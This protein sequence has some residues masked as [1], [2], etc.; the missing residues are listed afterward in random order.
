MTT[1]RIGKRRGFA[2]IWGWALPACMSCVGIGS[3]HAQVNEEQRAAR[4]AQQ[5]QI[6]AA[7]MLEANQRRITVYDR[8]GNEL[9]TV[10]EPDIYGAPVLSPDRSR[11]AVIRRGPQLP[12][13]PL[14]SD[15]VVLDIETEEASRVTTSEPGE[16]PQNVV[17]SPDGGELAF[18]ALRGSRYNIYRRPAV[19]EG[20]AT[21]VY[22][23]EGEPIRLSDWSP[24]GR[25]LAFSS[26]ANASE[27]RLYTIDLESGGEPVV[28]AEADQAMIAPRFSPDSRYLAFLSL[29]E[30]SVDHYVMPVQA[31]GRETWRISANGTASF[32]FWDADDPLF[33]HIDNERRLMAISIDTSGDSFEF[34]EERHIATLPDTV[35]AN[36]VL[37]LFSMSHD[38]ERLLVSLPPRPELQQIA[39]WD[40]NGNEISRLGEPA[41]YDQPSFS[42]DGSRI[43]VQRVAEGGVGG[44][45]LLAFDVASGDAT[46]LT[47]TPPGFWLA[48]VWMPDG[49]HVAYSTAPLAPAFGDYS[50]IYR[51]RADGQGEAEEL[52]RSAT[53][54]LLMLG[55]MDVSPGN[56]YLMFDSAG[57][58]VTV[59]L[60][61]G[62]PHA[63]EAIDLLGAEFEAS[64]S[65]FSPDMRSV[66]YLYN[67]SGRSEVY[68]APFDTDAGMAIASERHQVSEAGAAGA[69]D[70]REDGRELYYLS[71]ILD[72]PELNDF[73]VMAV[74]VTPEPEF[75]T[76]EP[77]TLFDVTLPATITTTLV[78]PVGTATLP[79]WQNVSPDG[80]RFAFVLPASGAE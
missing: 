54:V 77:R 13:M 15:I 65:R 57:W 6:A 11:I 46:E 27:G 50:R 4:E 71:E 25:Y 28:V 38:G 16:G 36:N 5:R 80:Q 78:W 9:G 52:F 31:D 69:L 43:L 70:W 55:L 49:E 44:G 73:R 20:E 64:A 26:G 68:L 72:T 59:P 76:G 48:P 67:E 24:D 60:A 14:S 62:D 61:G 18:S 10:G 30:S 1:T 33:Y 41:F 2:M 8:D 7:R 22:S 17:W 34:G 45:T 3:A 79:L 32:G 56:D 75:E 53:G 21:L 12:E 51:L 66:A 35:P 29:A 19:A 63:R 42:P 23:H 58:V 47:G 74:N 40:R 37:D 39:V